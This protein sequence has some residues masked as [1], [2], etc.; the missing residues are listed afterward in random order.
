MYGNY[1]YG[2]IS[3]NGDVSVYAPSGYFEWLDF[4]LNFVYFIN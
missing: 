4:E 2:V 3:S 1:L